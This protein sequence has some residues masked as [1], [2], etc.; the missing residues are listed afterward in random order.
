MQIINNNKKQII[1][2]CKYKVFIQD[3]NNNNFLL[4]KKF[5]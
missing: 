3:I 4:L 2:N 5:I 1:I